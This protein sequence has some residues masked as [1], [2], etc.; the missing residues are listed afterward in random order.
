MNPKKLE[1]PK[2]AYSVKKKRQK[3]GFLPKGNLPPTNCQI[4]FI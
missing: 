1:P 4:D 2:E 3:L